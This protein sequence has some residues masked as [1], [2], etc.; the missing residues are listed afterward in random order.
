MDLATELE[1]D[2]DTQLNS[3]SAL[4]L[5]L[6][7][8]SKGLSEYWWVIEVVFAFINLMKTEG[9]QE[10]NYEEVWKSNLLKWEFIE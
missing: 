7:L 4:M 6:T 8:T 3:F 2:I 1:V 5:K 9:P 10:W